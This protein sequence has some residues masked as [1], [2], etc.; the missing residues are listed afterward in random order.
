[1]EPGELP[2][3]LRSIRDRL[4]AERRTLARDGE[5][6]E[7]LPHVARLAGAGG[8]HRTVIYSS[9]RLD[10][11]D[12]AIAE[13]VAHYRKLGAA[14]E[15]KVYAHDAPADLRQRLAR[16]GFAVGPREAVVVL[17]LSDPPAWVREPGDIDVVRVE[18]REQV[19]LFRDAAVE[20][21][22]KDYG[23][24]TVLRAIE[25]G[26]T[27][28]LAYV[29]MIDGRAASIGRLYTHPDSLF[30]G[31]YGGGTRA[32]Y[33]GRGLSRAVVAARARDA[34]RL[35]AR[36]LLVDALP[37]S[38]PILER[39][40]FVHLTDTWACEWEPRDPVRSSPSS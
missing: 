7:V 3:D 5:T 32:A 1:M 39:L 22:G 34:I 33:R 11:A 20:I 31:L 4:D 35:G 37:T 23:V 18:R 16:H 17:D 2:M 38:R 40:G 24:T 19:E 13:Q 36:V 9:L 14:F 6:L 8:S 21:F 30:G 29:A 25:A 26:S 27:Q 28:H 15:W 10:N 12:E